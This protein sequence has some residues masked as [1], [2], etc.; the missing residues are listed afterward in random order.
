MSTLS[1]LDRRMLSIHS[2]SRI[3]K[4]ALFPAQ[5]FVPF[6]NVV[7][8]MV[9]PSLISCSFRGTPSTGGHK[10]ALDLQRCTAARVQMQNPKRQN[11]L[12]SNAKTHERLTGTSILVSVVTDFVLDPEDP[13]PLVISE[14]AYTC[15][16]FFWWENIQLE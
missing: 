5:A 8:P 1:D 3:L 9:E 6:Y 2:P 12:F 14:F 4:P 15:L 13:C 11:V 10:W 16:S 7:P